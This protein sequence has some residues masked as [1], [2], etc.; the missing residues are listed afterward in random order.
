MD[1]R[2][3]GLLA[4][5]QMR[6]HVLQH[7]DCIVHH[8]T[9]RE[10]KRGHRD[11]V[12][13]AAAG[14]EVHQRSDEGDGDGEDDDEGG[15]PAS[16]E[17]EY[18]Q[19]DHREGDEYGLDEGVDG[20]HDLLGGVEYLVYL[21]VG[22]QGFLDLLHLL[23]HSAAHVY[24]VGAGLLL[25]DDSR[26]AD[27]VGVGFLLT[28]LGAVADDGH[29]P[30]EHGL[31]AVVANYDVE[32]FGRI[33]ELLLHTEGVSV[34]A[35][36]DVAGGKVA[37]LGRDYLGDGGYAQ[38]VGLEL[39]GIAVDLDLA[40]RRTVDADRSHALDSGQRGGHL[41]VQDLV[42][43]GHGLGCGC[44]E[45]HDRHVLGAEL[46]D[47]RRG[48][49]VGH[50][51]VHHVELVAHVV[52]GLFDVGAVFELE[53]EEADVFLALGT[54]FLEVLYAVQGVLEQL[55]EVGLDI[56]RVRSLVG[57]HHHDGVGVELGEEGDGGVDQR[58]Y[59]EDDEGHENEGR[60][61]RI[62]DSC[63]DYAHGPLV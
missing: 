60:R 35:Y 54:E 40:G 51:G 25:D 17:D 32:K 24:G 63:F 38:V 29:I 12:Q 52:G 39:A 33:L 56:R 16:E 28:L 42:E 10:R 41:V 34:G 47:Y 14:E 21:D 9:Y 61:H 20:V 30:Q 46:E 27:A 13:G 26:C 53:G 6:G 44:G 45:H 5:L 43:A 15:L 11:Y 1:G 58:V 22:G 19:H 4:A 49:P 23:V 7:H 3:H 50:D 57:T 62:L 8:H 31:A 59:A 18:H 2:L 48:G 55:G 37:V 36:V